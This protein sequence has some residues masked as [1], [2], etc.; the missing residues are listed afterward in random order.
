MKERCKLRSVYIGQGAR[1]NFTT[2]GGAVALPANLPPLPVRYAIPPQCVSYREECL[3][4]HT[5]L[6]NSPHIN[7][8]YITGVYYGWCGH[9]SRLWRAHCDEQPSLRALY[10]AGSR[11]V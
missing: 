4:T 1:V 9:Q 8:V 5:A 7:S 6:Q 3:Y 2:S 11:V 10:G